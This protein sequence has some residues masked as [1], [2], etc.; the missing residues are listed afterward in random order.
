MIRWLILAAA[1]VARLGGAPNLAVT[2][3]RVADENRVGKFDSVDGRAHGAALD[4]DGRTYK[5]AHGRAF[6]RDGS[7]YG[8]ADGA[9]LD[10]DGRAHG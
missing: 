7:T 6:H 9:A 4:R 1:V 5:R 2:P 8:R 10:R 3:K